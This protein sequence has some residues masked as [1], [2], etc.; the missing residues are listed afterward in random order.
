M[1]ISVDALVTAG[2]DERNDVTVTVNNWVIVV[3]EEDD[4][5]ITESN[6]YQSPSISPAPSISAA[7][8]A[9]PVAPA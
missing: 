8:S 9:A 6:G 5:V 4:M 1:A 2:E 3:D 7:P